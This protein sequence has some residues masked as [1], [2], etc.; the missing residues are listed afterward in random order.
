MSNCIRI[1][2]THSATPPP[3]PTSSRPDTETRRHGEG[4]EECRGAGE[5]RRRGATYPFES[6]WSLR[7]EG[8][9]IN[10]SIYDLSGRLIRILVDEP[11]NHL[12]IQPSNHVVWDGKDSSG[13][14]VTSG[15]YFCRMQAGDLSAERK[16]VLIR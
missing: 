9:R 6:R 13:R 15:I 16:V 2:R 10:L 8:Q 7:T 4:E 3:S 5:Q 12:T 11:S 14:E 1:R